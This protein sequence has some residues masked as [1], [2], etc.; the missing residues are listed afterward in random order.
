MKSL[1]N[2]VK[3]LEENSIC[4]S[5]EYYG[6]ND[7][8]TFWDVKS[9][10]DNREYFQNELVACKLQRVNSLSEYLDYLCLR[11]FV[12]FQEMIPAIKSDEDKQIIQ[13][14]SMIAKEKY[15]QIKNGVIIQFINGNYKEIFSE[16]Y[17]KYSL[18][19]ITL[20]LIV[21]FQS[22]I[23]RAVFE[24]LAKNYNYLLIDR[25]QDLQKKFEKEPELFAML[26][27]QKNLEEIQ[28][29]RFDNVFPIFVSIWKG[30]NTSLKE[31]V[32]P[33]IDNI[34]TD[35]EKLIKN[36]DSN[37]YRNIL[38]LEHQFQYIYK[39]IDQIRH[40]K[41][42]TFLKYSEWIETKLKD[43]LKE[44][45]HKFTNEL[46]AGEIVSH[47][48]SL[49]DWEIQMLSLTH[50]HHNE[51]DM[52]RYVS[53]FSYPSKGKQSIIDSVSSNISSDDYFTRSHQRELSIIL[54]L[55]AA[56]ISA[57]WH[58][59]EIFP[60]CLQWYDE[61]LS[62][63][64]EQMGDNIDLAEDLEM[65]YIMLQPVILSDE[66]E[67]K[68]IAPMCYGA[69]MFICALTEKLLRTLYIYLM[70]DEMY[71]PLTSATLGALLTPH[72]Q[73]MVNIFGEDHLKNLSFFFCTV[74]DKKIGMNYRNALAHWIGLG[75][76]DINS[77]LVAK[78]FY[79]YTDVINT[80]FLFFQKHHDIN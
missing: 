33:I 63:I 70:K 66:A 57:I 14:V 7:Y 31:I 59:K 64:S 36:L 61:F 25:F 41:A 56:T 35:T 80:I 39:F 53:R 4:F 5:L 6:Q 20:E 32:S 79:L 67:N 52:I 40:P 11:K 78:L 29:L 55:G 22:G 1:Q 44:H 73:E 48:K 45:G 62:F 60:D 17:H 26:F 3:G 51:S 75:D 54:A 76:R 47:I 18:P 72:N 46:P 16:E 15:D 2:I 9:V 68:D 10:L 65:L 27:R 19:H 58:D 12:M 38:I 77:M 71:V 13:S 43:A 42:N 50:D 21:K 69:A 34:I 28:E 74:G 37:D 49:P 23:D 30:S 24:Y 8:G